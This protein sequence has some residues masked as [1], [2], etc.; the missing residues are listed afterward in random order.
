MDHCSDEIEKTVLNFRAL[1]LTS[2]LR[3][4][5]YL[6]WSIV[7]SMIWKLPDQ[8][9]DFDPLTSTCLGEDFNFFPFS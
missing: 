7:S 4:Y 2:S 8:K 5:K 3:T 1:F 6:Y 9:T